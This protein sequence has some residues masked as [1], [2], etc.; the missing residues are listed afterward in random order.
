M[1][2]E[3]LG[4]LGE[5]ISGFGVII[6]LIY[7]AVQVRQNTAALQ[8][9]SRQD[10]VSGYRAHSRL[11][12]ET[13]GVRTFAEGLRGYPDMPFDERALFWN[14][15]GDHAVFFQGVYALHESGTLEDET[16]EAYLDWF[17][18]HL[19]TS[20][21]S[22]FWLQGRL[23]MPHRVVEAVDARLAQGGLPDIMEL[24]PYALDALGSDNP[25]TD[26]SPNKA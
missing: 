2:L 5:F 6:T 10:I 17:A 20:G 26:H 22:A 24:S 14:L 16:Y 25:D 7:L 18:C 13:G 9:S 19:T 4:N 8:T 21:G 23:I 15:L 1:I 3:A 12:L 11:L